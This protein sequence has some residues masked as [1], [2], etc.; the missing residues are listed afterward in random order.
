MADDRAFDPFRELSEHAKH[1]NAITESMPDSV[2]FYEYMSGAL[3]WPD[4]TTKQT[5]IKVIW[6]LRAV[7]AYRTSAMF[8]GSK[9]KHLAIWNHARSCFPAWVGFRPERSVATDSLV[10]IYRAGEARLRGDL[11]NR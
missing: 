6:A 7:W 8:G 9:D 11:E 4:E 2:P 5:P 10:L 3:V 1:L